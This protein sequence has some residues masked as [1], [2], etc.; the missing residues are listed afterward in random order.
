[1]S[2]QAVVAAMQSGSP[3]AQV[4][5]I[6]HS[7]WAELDT[8][9]RQRVPLNTIEIRNIEFDAAIKIAA[10]LGVDLEPAQTVGDAPVGP[11]L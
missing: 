10:I 3:L 11:K 9:M 4:R 8:G 5:T 1:M 7:A 6:L 2:K